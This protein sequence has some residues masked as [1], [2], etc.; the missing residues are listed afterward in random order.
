MAYCYQMVHVYDSDPV[1]RNSVPR[2]KRTANQLKAL[3][4]SMRNQNTETSKA[5]TSKTETSKVET[6]GAETSK[7]ETK[8]SEQDYDSE[9]DEWER[10]VITRFGERV[11]RDREEKRRKC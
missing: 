11:R 9:M 8:E 10:E 2:P 4:R 1:H 6:S 5:E 3:H 7:A